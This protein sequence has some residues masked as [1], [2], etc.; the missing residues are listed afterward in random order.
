MTLSRFDRN[1]VLKTPRDV[2]RL[3]ERLA[4]LSE[5]TRLDDGEEHKE[6]WALADSLSDLESSFREFL[7]EILPKLASSEGEELYDLLLETAESFRHILYHI[8][9]HRNFLGT[10]PQPLMCHAG[11]PRATSGEIRRK[12]I[13]RRHF[14]IKNQAS[15]YMKEIL[16][17]PTIQRFSPIR[18]E[19]CTAESLRKRRQP[20]TATRSAT[21]FRTPSTTQTPSSTKTWTTTHMVAAA[22]RRWTKNTASNKWEDSI[23]VLL[24]LSTMRAPVP[25]Q[26][27]RQ[28]FGSPWISSASECPCSKVLRHSWRQ[29]CQALSWV[30]SWRANP[31][32]DTVRPLPSQISV[33][34]PARRWTQSYER[35]IRRKFT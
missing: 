18:A 32:P 3:A 9:V 14:P 5:V 17:S 7:E 26:S 8:L 27:P 2:T 12:E 35:T 25:T 6:A 29:A 4:Q 30:Q 16:T 33:G 23:P 22:M 1:R 13:R 10:W 34:C 31:R 21:A 11:L 20:K 24:A 15:D 19:R 28:P